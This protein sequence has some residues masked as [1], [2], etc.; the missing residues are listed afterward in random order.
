[1][2][3]YRGDTNAAGNC[4]AYG[5]T[6]TKCKKKN[7]LAKVCQSSSKQTER[8]SNLGARKPKPTRDTRQRVHHVQEDD[9]T[10]ELSS[11]ESIY[12]AR[13]TKDTN[14]YAVEI[15]VSARKSEA[16]IP[17]KFQIDTGAS[18]ST[19]TLQDFKKITDENP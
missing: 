10:D 11:D 16:A 3:G 4:P 5:Q 12:T 7:H 1:M 13:A 6:C 19:M 18:C 15:Y 14:N 17:L 9:V 8:K 2:T